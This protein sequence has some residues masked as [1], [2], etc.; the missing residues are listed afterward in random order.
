MPIITLPD[1]SK[2][3]F[4]GPVCAMDIAE[5]IGPGL[6]KAT[7]C[8]S[9]DGELKDVSDSISH[10]ASVSLITAKDPEGLEVIRHSFAH[11]I[12]HAGKQLF[13][14][15]KMA[16]GPVIEHGFYYDVDYERQ[17]TLDDLEALETRI[18]ELVKT[19]YPVIKRWASREEAI[20]EF[21]ERAEPYKLEI[22]EQDIPDD[23][24]AIGLYHHQE[25]LDM[26]RGPHVHNTRF[27]RHFKLTNVTG[28]YWRGNV[29]N[30]QLQRIYGIAFT[31]KQDL[32]AHLKFLEEAAKRDHRN[33]AKTLDL[34]HLQEEAPGM[35]FWHPNGWTVYRVLEDYIRDRLEHSG[36]QEIRTP[37]LVDQRLWE[38]SG[39]WDKYQENM[40]VTSSESRDYAVKPMNCPCHV[41]IY[42]KKIT[43]YRELPI[44]LAEFGSCHRNEPSG[45][46]HGLMRVRNFVQ[47]D[48]HI[49]CT[50]DQ[51]TDEVKTFNKLL[52]EVYR[53]MGFDDMIVRISTRPEKRVG[54]DETWDKAEKALSDALDELGV[55]WEELPGEGAFYGPKIEY[56]LKDCLGRVWQ[57]GTMQV[58][59]SMP[60]RLGAEYVAEDGSKQTPVMLHR[61]ILGSLERFVGILL[62]NTM[63]WLPPWLSPTQAVVLTIT[64]SQHEYAENVEKIL[65]AQGLRVKSD[66][67]N[68]KIGYKIRHHT[69]QR[70]PYLLVVGDKE[71][72][73]QQVAVRTRSGEDLGAMGLQA[74][75]D[76]LHS[77]I[78]MRGRFVTGSEAG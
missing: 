15:I 18:Q 64:D 31:S 63:G 71:V 54:D 68:E 39:H 76:K 28:A 46:L 35:V 6:A 17:L 59:F 4:E 27:L 52:T 7:I 2:R 74:F 23:G 21:N 44:R 14:G 1:G 13:P 48:A 40:F 8:A 20:A 30:K 58:D 47:D 38:A 77:E 10:D 36:Y 34:F 55:E 19:D 78:R 24:H 9:V 3:E 33:L 70:V 43:S 50:E 29:N 49:F 37:Q 42:N 11:L 69:L 56:S 60:G 41:Q 45:S 26:C 57:C 72:E 65:A 61:A 66:L 75:A 53:D 67:R 25:Y 73:N 51:I 5:S 32:D 12:G 16:I 22:I 62:E